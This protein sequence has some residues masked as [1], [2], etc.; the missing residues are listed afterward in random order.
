MSPSDTPPHGL[1]AEAPPKGVVRVAREAMATRFEIVLHGQD[2]I[3][4]RAAA[5]EALGE[6]E[7]LESQLSLY[8]ETSEVSRINALAARQPVR[9]SPLL[10]R[11][12]HQ[13][14]SLSRITRGT[15]DITVAPLMRCW[16]FLREGGRQA[17]PPEVREALEVVG[18]RHVVLDPDTMTVSFDTPGVMI[19]LGAIGKGLAVDVAMDRL[20]E[21][22]IA[23][24]LVHGGTSTA[25]AMGVQPDGRPWRVAVELPGPAVGPPATPRVESFALEGQS[26]SVS[27]EWG[28]SF[29]AG[30]RVYG[31]VL[32]PRTG[33]PVADTRLAAVRTPS[34]T[35]SDALS[36]ALMVLGLEGMDLLAAARP[37]LQ[38]LL[39]RGRADAPEVHRFG[40][41]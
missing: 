25:C 1:P 16:G 13:C 3:R 34:A 39:L 6:I 15:F 2:P 7:D 24:A 4:L 40:P 36:T 29:R 14:A 17:E 23:H 26:L 30:T 20:K 35:E 5:D 11:L 32:D 41:G 33:E 28:K 37:G 9:V 18:M 19:D 31:H 21:A 38:G 27:A 8:R 12:L 10:F 22:G